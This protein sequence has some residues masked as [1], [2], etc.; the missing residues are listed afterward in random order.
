[1]DRILRNEQIE[2]FGD[3]KN[4]RTSA[5]VDD[6]VEATFLAGLKKPP[7]ITMD[8]SGTESATTL[9][10]VHLISDELGKSP[11]LSFSSPRPGDQ[12]HTVGDNSLAKAHLDWEP[13]TTLR[14]GIKSLIA[15]TDMNYVGD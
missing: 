2:I 10:L 14:E 11:K 15:S 1:V 6:V 7:N 4:S 12:R 13:R 9:D 8:I 3:G 5:Y